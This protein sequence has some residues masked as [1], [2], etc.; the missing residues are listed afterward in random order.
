MD[1]VQVNALQLFVTGP[2]G[3]MISSTCF[4][5]QTMR[6]GN[7]V[8]SPKDGFKAIAAQLIQAGLMALQ[9]TIEEDVTVTYVKHLK[10]EYLIDVRSMMYLR[11]M[12]V[13]GRYKGFSFVNIIDPSFMPD[14]S[15]KHESSDE[16]DEGQTD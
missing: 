2:T 3:N 10:L 5:D 7:V 11:N 15:A 6:F 8:L 13:R 9:D 1:E 12:F 16:S 4:T 14:L